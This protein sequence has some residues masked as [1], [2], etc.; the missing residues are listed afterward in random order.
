MRAG[1]T[2]AVSTH[3]DL[4]F[5]ETKLMCA[6]T[7]VPV[8]CEKTSRFHAKPRRRFHLYR[9]T[10]PLMQYQAL[11]C[12]YGS[13]KEATT[14]LASSATPAAPG[15][16]KGAGQRWAA[17]S[18]AMQYTS[19]AECESDSL[20]R[21][22]RT[23]L[24]MAK[25]RR[26][27]VDESAFQMTLDQFREQYG[28][29]PDRS[30][31]SMKFYRPPSPVDGKVDPH[32][33]LL[34]AFATEPKVGVKS[35]RDLCA[36]MHDEAIPRAIFVLMDGMTPF[37]RSELRASPFRIEEF[38]EI[39]LRI[40]IT[41]HRRVPAHRLIGNKETRALLQM[42]RIRKAQLPRLPVTDPVARYYG[43]KPGQVVRIVRRSETTGQST[44][45][46]VVS[47]S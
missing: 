28:D 18:M 1:T 45:Y 22:R 14:T 9:Y 2:P 13:C 37:A 35:L 16:S 11:P 5:N 29:V 25:D 27:A 42:Y 36:R 3:V 24:Q 32:D 19:P 33:T 8:Y 4:F 30:Q 41:H 34:V 39:D 17:A 38:R 15:G 31:L 46:R 43:F 23:L 20:F 6:H 47:P 10:T 7:R 26:Y 21:V 44:I 40:N 12:G